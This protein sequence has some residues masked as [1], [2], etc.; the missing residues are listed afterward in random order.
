VSP[1]GSLKTKRHLLFM[2]K[3]SALKSSI[4]LMRIER[5]H[6]PHGKHDTSEALLN[7]A[8]LIECRR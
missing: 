7:F 1:L 2:Y 6:A 3:A 8:R 4:Q 5:I